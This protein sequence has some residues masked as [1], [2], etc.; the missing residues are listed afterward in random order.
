MGVDGSKDIP[1][2]PVR[3]LNEFVYCPRLAHLMWVQ[4]EFAHNAYTVEGKLKHRRVDKA[5]KP[6]PENPPEEVLIHAR[7]V[8]LSSTRLGITAKIDLVEGK[9]NRVVPVDYKRGKRPHTSKGVYDPERVQLCAQGLLLRE[10]GYE[11]DQGVIYFIASKERV[12]VAYD[13]ELLD[14]TLRSID[15]LSVLAS[16]VDVPLPLEDSPKCPRCSLVGICL[17]D[18]VGFL[19][20]RDIEPRPIFAAEEGG[21]PLYVQEPGAYVRKDGMCFVIEENRTKLDEARLEEISQVVLFGHARLSTP[22]LH[23]C[24]RRQIPVSYLSY[25]GWFLGHTVGTGHRNVETRTHQ[26]WASFDKAMCLRLAR[27][28][29][30]AKIANCRTMLRRNWRPRENDG[31]GRAP[32]DLMDHVLIMDMGPV[33]SVKLPFEPLSGD[34][35]IV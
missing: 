32:K 15:E 7:S 19:T 29:V 28:L 22:G 25:G 34:A 5:G 4:S 20:R 21:L 13:Q 16:G 23:E 14:L 12:K 11:C 30:A 33:G 17:P 26:Y 8:S 18:E 27:S 24:F 9:G 6:L 3:L 35:V 31:D 1:L 2:I 10:H